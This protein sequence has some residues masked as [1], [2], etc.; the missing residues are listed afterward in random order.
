MH[1]DSIFSSVFKFPRGNISNESCHLVTTNQSA[2]FSA[3]F[4]FCLF[5]FGQLEWTGSSITFGNQ[6]TNKTVSEICTNYALL[7]KSHQSYTIRYSTFN[8]NVVTVFIF[9]LAYAFVMTS[10]Y[11]D[12]NLI[13][14]FQV[15]SVKFNDLLKKNLTALIRAL[16][17]LRMSLTMTANC[18]GCCW[19]TAC[20]ASV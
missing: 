19:N 1:L 12:Y 7:V 14:T 20:K 13:T 5:V 17:C 15:T 16:S 4:F 18:R 6:F 10:T 3:K 11:K 9:M 2:V 8:C